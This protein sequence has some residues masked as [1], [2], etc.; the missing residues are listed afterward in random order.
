MYRI[1]PIAIFLI[2]EINRVKC[3]ASIQVVCVSSSRVL[4]LCTGS[5]FF[6][7]LYITNAEFN[8]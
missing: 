6:F 8:T 5:V 1:I 7:Y 3:M 4:S 2:L